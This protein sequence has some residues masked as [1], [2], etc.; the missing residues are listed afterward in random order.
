MGDG[1]GNHYDCKYQIASLWEMLLLY[2]IFVL[3]EFSEA[4]NFM[5]DSFE[6][7]RIHEIRLTGA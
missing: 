5:F 1:D 3:L 4:G 6:V 7:K 2:L